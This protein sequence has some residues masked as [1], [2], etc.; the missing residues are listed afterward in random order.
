MMYQRPARRYGPQWL[1][2]VDERALLVV[3]K[4]QELG[5]AAHS[6]ASPADEAVKG[7]ANIA[8]V[9]AARLAV[10]G[11]AVAELVSRILPVAVGQETSL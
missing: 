1:T 6:S 8:G 7:A 2:V 5:Q 4:G 3:F 10:V 9:T 11:S